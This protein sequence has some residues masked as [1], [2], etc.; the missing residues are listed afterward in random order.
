METES[1]VGTKTERCERLS[2]AVLYG[3]GLASLL[4]ALSSSVLPVVLIIIVLLLTM[5]IRGSFAN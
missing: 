1:L 3:V 5:G 2:S 4:S